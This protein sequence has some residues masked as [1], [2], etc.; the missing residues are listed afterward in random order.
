M[1]RRLILLVILT[2]AAMLM[3]ACSSSGPAPVSGSA[4]GSTAH[5]TPIP[6]G[7]IGSYSGSFAESHA[8]GQ[9]IVQAWADSVNAAGGILGHPIK[10]YVE[11]SAGNASTGLTE[12]KTLIQQDHVV[13][14]VGQTDTNPSWG[15]YAS[16]AGVPVVG[17]ATSDLDYLTDPDWYSVGTNI[18]ALIGG[19]VD[20][21]QHY[22]S[23][24]A[25]LYCAEQAS[26]KAAATLESALGAPV[27]EKL[28]YQA[29]VPASAPDFTQYCLA[30]KNAG[31]NSYFLGTAAT[32]YLT[33][34]AQCRQLGYNAPFMIA[35]VGSGSQLEGQASLNGLQFV[36]TVM[37]WFVDSTPA[38]KEF[39]DAVAK[40]AP[41]VGTAQLPINEFGLADW[42]SGKLFEAAIKASGATAATPITSALV[43]KGL[44]A[45]KD[46]TL[47]GLAPQALSYTPGKPTLFNCYFTSNTQNSKLVAPSLQPICPS[48]ATV[49]VIDAIAASLAK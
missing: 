24:T 35:G 18:V 33:I 14:I 1:R 4:S 47:G 21:A 17:G 36:D 11:D 49:K 19:I 40:Y 44:Y 41:N 28:T 23:K 20:T 10:L 43:K 3:V 37:P 12:M 16:S 29:G 31:A 8:D 38:T 30:M 46:E 48:A 2:M 15:S 45:L 27:G 42:A 22:G 13:A 39:H 9:Y 7:T 5:G 25:A 26:C 32:Q 34:S 6:I